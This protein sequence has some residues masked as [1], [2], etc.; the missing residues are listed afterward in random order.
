MPVAAV[1]AGAAVTAGAAAYSSRQ[2]SRAAE[3]AADAQT[4]AGQDAAQ[5]TVEAARIGADAQTKANR[6]NIQF[7]KDV[8]EQQRA[9]AQP[10]RE[11]GAQALQNIQRGIANGT[12][13]PGEFSYAE[14]EPS[15]LSFQFNFEEDPGAEFRR[16]QAIDALNRQAAARGGLLSG[17]QLQ[18]AQALA[19]DMASQEYQ[20][21]FARALSQHQLAQQDEQQRLQAYLTNRQ[22]AAMA[23]DSRA[24][25][26]NQL[27]NQQ[28]TLAGVGQTANQGIAQAGQAMANQVG[29]STVATGNAL[30]G[31]AH[32]TGQ[33]LSGQAMNTGNALA[34]MYQQQGQASANAMA[35]I[36]NAIQGGIQ[37]YLFASLI[38]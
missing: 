14:F 21:A 37:N 28:A 27:F 10:W 3:R 7:Q 2:Q 22:G 35:G 34:S 6:E 13:D 25:R 38:K 5:A 9:D 26:A 20:N 36:N 18:A 1:V 29:Q 32:Q 4:Q 15:D 31:Q 11:V 33:A 8:F 24:Q 23:F 30:A 17:G 19:S 12:F 16:Q